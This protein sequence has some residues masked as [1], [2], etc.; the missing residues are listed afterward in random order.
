VRRLAV[1]A[2]AALLVALALAGCQRLLGVPLTGTWTGVYEPV[3]GD[4]SGVLLL[5]LQVSGSAVSGTWESSLPGTLAQGSAS[6][7]V[8]SLLMLELTST[9]VADCSFHL[10][11][12]Q[13]GD[14]LVGGYTADCGAVPGGWVE[15]SKR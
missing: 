13:R 8:G 10:L 7:V 1:R 2:A 4:A 3:E 15:L 11:A 14:R 6:G 12:E 5:D 9:T